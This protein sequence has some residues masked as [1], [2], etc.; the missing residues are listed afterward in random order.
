MADNNT[1][2]AQKT[3]EELEKERIKKEKQKQKEEEKA[4]KLA[5]L[6]A[7][8][9]ALK[10]QEEKKAQKAQ[11]A[12]TDNNT[13]EKEPKKKDD[14]DEPF[15]NDTP[16]GEKKDTTKPMRKSYD[17]KAVEAAWYEWWEKKQFFHADNQSTNKEKFV[18]VIPPPNVTG[19]LHLG[20]ALTNSVEDTITRWHRMCGKVA[21]WV[22]GSDHAGIATQA[23]VEKKLWKD[24]QKTRHDLGREKFI[25]EVW[26][27]KNDY[28]SRIY[29]QLRRIGSSVDW[30]RVA[31]TMDE[32]RSRAV[33]EAFVRMYNDGLIYRDTR[34]VNWSCKLNTAISDIEVDHIQI[35]KRTKLKVPGHQGEYEFGVLTEFAYKVDGQDTEIVVAT[36]RP[37]TMLGD[38]AVAVHPDDP[39]YKSLHGKFLIHPFHNRKIPIVTDS[40][41]VDMKFGTGAVKVTPAHDPNDYAC[42]KRNNLQ[43]INI[44]NENGTLNAEAGPFQ[45]MM[46]FDARVAV[47]EALKEKGLY[48]GTKENPMTLG[49]CSRSKDVI[50]PFLKPQW[51]VNCKPMAERAVK[52]VETGELEIIPASHKTTWYQWLN[53]IHDWCISRQLWWGHRCPAYL[54]IIDGKRPDAAAS[55]HWVVGR[56]YNEALENALKK[57][58][59]VAK[60]KIT[61][62]QDPD[63]LDTW[64][65]SGLFP[66]SVFGWPDDT[67]DMR[68]FYPTT[69]LE[70]GHD[71]LFFWVARMVMMG[72]QLTGQLPFKQVFLH[73]MVRDSH[74]RKMSKSLGNV[75]NPIDMIEGISLD[76]LHNT[77]LEGNLDPREV[78]KAKSGQKADFPNGIPEC[79]TDAMR[80][81]LVAYTTQGRD[82]NLDVLRVA[83]YRNFC[84]KLWNATKFALMTL[85]DNFKP[86]DTERK[87]VNTSNPWE[88]WILSRLSNAIKSANEGFQAYDFAKVTT[89]IYNFWLYELCDI[90]LESMK[91]LARSTDNNASATLASAKETLYTCLENGLRLLHPTMP[92]VTEELW[93]RLPRRA[94][95]AH[96]E[97]ICIAQ[98]PQ[99]VAE[100]IH[101]E[102]EKQ[103]E[104]VMNV[105]S[106]VRRMRASF[107]LTAQKPKLYINLTNEAI[108][109]WLHKFTDVMIFLSHSSEIAVTLNQTVPPEGCAVEIVDENAQVYMLVK[110]IVDIAAE[111]DKLEKKNA[112][113]Q[114]DYTKLQKNTNDKLPENKKQENL[115]RLEAMKA[116]LDTANTTIANLKKF[117]EK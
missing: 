37:E 101:E 27:W 103:V 39:R 117:L 26:K 91:P 10:A 100:W 44:L 23:V 74:G 21:L 110:G 31:F 56:D 29:N 87:Q 6:Q 79:G 38:T 111:I 3:P 83:A 58:P 43:F 71:I 70:T 13:K 89:A 24:F 47:I 48:R 40:I 30:Q 108:N 96:I 14:A 41:L 115:Q 106:S 116:E 113:I 36:T 88:A 4:A 42:G 86:A 35:E 64:F 7:K 11:T 99:F 76:N 19:Q 65:S 20:H 9:E 92:F 102:S 53:N 72:L 69:L 85:G 77:L 104:F 62:E 75:I 93:Q 67:A 34:L 2:S 8:K 50:E 114:A 33:T 112:K 57:N 80:F 22:P 52:A 16:P 46:R 54:V 51:Y 68:A 32:T 90:Y 97:S 107:M 78:E 5:K 61:L 82:I 17:P 98:Y 12:N 1:P 81:A 84:N 25:E 63:V 105:V 94:S 95:H 28:G 66:F 59:G 109:K 55:T 45:G 73:A 18:M 60:D 49:L 15:V